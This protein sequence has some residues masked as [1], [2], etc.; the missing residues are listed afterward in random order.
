MKG[1]RCPGEAFYGISARIVEWLPRTNE[2][3][4]RSNSTGAMTSDDESLSRA[5][6]VRAD[7][8]ITLVSHCPCI[9][10]VRNFAIKMP[11]SYLAVDLS[12][13]CF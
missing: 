3:S 5:N 4:S 8:V 11:M 12:I 2:K 9:A 7:G 13:V 1:G 10:M 6:C